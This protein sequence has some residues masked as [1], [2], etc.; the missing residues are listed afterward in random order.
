MPA[1]YTTNNPNPPETLHGWLTLS[2]DEAAMKS[3]APIEASNHKTNPQ[4]L[5]H[6][7]IVKAITERLEMKSA[8]SDFLLRLAGKDDIYTI[9]R[10]VQGLADYEKEPDAVNMT[11]KDYLR[12]GYPLQSNSDGQPPLFYC[13]LIEEQQGE[14]S[15]AFGMALIWLGFQFDSGRFLYL[16]DLFLEESYR[17]KGA[18]SLIMKTLAEIAQS[19]M[20][21]DMVWQALEWDP[22]ALAF[23]GKIGAKIREG[24]ITS[25]YAGNNLKDFVQNEAAGIISS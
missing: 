24:V 13:I 12:D 11:G 17:K 6:C 18:D 1:W 5:D 8:S 22:P 9:V 16:E 20:C 21:H 15:Y 23:Y 3:Y 25:R 10:L 19:L 4:V 14:S 2:M 7:A